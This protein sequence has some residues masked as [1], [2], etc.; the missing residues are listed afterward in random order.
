MKKVM[1]SVMALAVVLFASCEKEEM[2]GIDGLPATGNTFLEQHFTGVKVN[3]VK[4]EK[5]GLSGTEY[6]VYLENG[7]RVKFDKSGNWEEV[8]APDNIAIPTSF[9]PDNIVAYVAEHYPNIGIN[10]IDK[11]RNKYDVELVNGLDLE[12][13]LAGE[14]VRI[15]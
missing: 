4:K 11:E 13:N 1:Y 2:I 14:F 5:E 9:I 12:F 7:T 3:N 15:D 10:S 8:E 6:T